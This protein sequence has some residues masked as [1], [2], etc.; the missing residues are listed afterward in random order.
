MSPIKSKGGKR[1]LKSLSLPKEDFFV[2][3]ALEF[4]RPDRNEAM[5]HVCPTFQGARGIGAYVTSHPK[6]KHFRRMVM[7]AGEAGSRA[8]KLFMDYIV[9]Y[10]AQEKFND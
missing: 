7:A 9:W 5:S 1:R 8:H 2:M 10:E 4:G 6:G 3:V